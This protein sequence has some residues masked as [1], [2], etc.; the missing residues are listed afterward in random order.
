LTLGTVGLTAA[1]QLYAVDSRSPATI[2]IRAFTI[3]LMVGVVFTIRDYDRHRPIRLAG[4]LTALRN[5]FVLPI[6]EHS[7]LSKVSRAS[8]S[9]GL[10]VWEIMGLVLLVASALVAITLNL[11]A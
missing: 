5:G 1:D 6:D 9:Q 7:P 10:G 11:G 4:V 2:L 3:A 8:A